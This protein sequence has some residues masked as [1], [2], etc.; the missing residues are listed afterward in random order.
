MKSKL[1]LLIPVLSHNATVLFLPGS[2]LLTKDSIKKYITILGILLIS[3]VIVFSGLIN[4]K[5]I[6]FTRSLGA[7]IG[8]N[9]KLIYLVTIICAVLTFFVL[10]FLI[11]AKT[12]RSLI[13]VLI[14]I[15][16][17]FSVA[18]YFMGSQSY[19][20]LFYLFLAVCYPITSIFLEK[21][22]L[23]KRNQADFYLYILPLLLWVT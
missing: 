22:L 7:E 23:N 15:V 19:E 3:I 6:Y 21:R 8:G 12:N 14:Y 10:K 18:Y 1:L 11:N 16:F 5:S 17:I 4:F 20:R 13:I 2:M 9:I